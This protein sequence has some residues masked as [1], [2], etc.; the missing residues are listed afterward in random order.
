VAEEVER[1]GW[2]RTVRR[3]EWWLRVVEDERE[4]GSKERWN[5]QIAIE[6]MMKKV[7]SSWNWNE[8]KIDGIA[9][10]D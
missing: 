6:K 10:F 4:R 1:Q 2:Q 9:V 7:V 3:S 8:S 5:T